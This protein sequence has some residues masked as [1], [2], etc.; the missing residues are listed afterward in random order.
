M[1]IV[2]MAVVLLCVVVLTVSVATNTSS[3]NGKL[4]AVKPRVALPFR[5]SKL[6][7]RS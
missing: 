3:V 5:R 7:Y 6:L 2:P 1:K 4:K